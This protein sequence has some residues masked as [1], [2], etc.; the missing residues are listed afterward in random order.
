MDEVL[1][2]AIDD[3]A[4]EWQSQSKKMNPKEKKVVVPVK[5]KKRHN[6]FKKWATAK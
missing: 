6:L 2:T 3:L 1:E 5:E 4:G